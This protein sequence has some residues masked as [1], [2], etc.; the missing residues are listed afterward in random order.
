MRRHHKRQAVVLAA[1]ALA[2][3]AC[4]EGEA[5]PDVRADHTT[6]VGAAAPMPDSPPGKGVLERAWSLDLS[7]EPKTGTRI[8]VAGGQLFVPSSRGLNVHDARTGQERWHYRERGRQLRGYAVTGGAVVL[9]TTTPG[10]SE[11]RLV[12]LDAATGRRLWNG[13]GNLTVEDMTAYGVLAS[14]GVVLA[15]RSVGRDMAT[16]VD[17]LDA[18]TGKSRWNRPL[19]TG[20]VTFPSGVR[21]RSD[22]SVLVLVASCGSTAR[23]R[24]LDPAT[25]RVLW[26]RGAAAQASVSVRGGLTAI[27]SGRTH[28]L[29]RAG[30]DVATDDCASDCEFTVAGG[31][32]IV[33][34]P[35]TDGGPVLT[36]YDPGTGRRLWRR[37]V[38]TPG[39]ARLAAAGGRLQLL[40][41]SWSENRLG[42]PQPAALRSVDPATG[43][44][45]HQAALPWLTS[46]VFSALGAG[47][48]HSIVVTGERVFAVASGRD[49][50]F[51]AFSY[52]ASPAAGGPEELGGVPVADWPDACALGPSGMRAEPEGS[53]TVGTLKLRNVRC[54]YF[55]AGTM[56]T[57]S[58]VWVAPTPEKAR[59]LLVVEKG[60]GASESLGDEGHSFSAATGWQGRPETVVRVGRHIVHFDRAGDVPEELKRAVADKLGRR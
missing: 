7:G 4:A 37:T 10:S 2:A 21:V 20:C 56:T 17:G 3:G 27:T 43:E 22:A 42:P 31:R 60:K 44:D 49:G 46:R 23:I 12:G 19:G 14:G 28:V 33:A 54:A 38:P 36:G 53:A 58:I 16:V 59:E 11:D 15:E 50:K 18:R 40:T 1:V 32:P 47:K 30:R 26:D 55:D 35:E 6:A 51:R 48:I 13:K 25:G 45:E 24:A 41:D 5:A 57:V 34:R 8:A 29:D 9:Q 39:P 52:A